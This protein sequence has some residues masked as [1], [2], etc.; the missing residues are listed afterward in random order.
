M[1]VVKRLVQG[2]LGRIGYEVRALEPLRSYAAEL[3]HSRIYTT[4]TYS[5]WLNDSAFQAVYEHIS[6]NTMVDLYRCYDLWQLVAEAAKLDHGDIIEVGSYRGGSGCLMSARS[7]QLGL[8]A[9][10]YLC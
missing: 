6:Q 3:P 2:T 8:N 9:T 10:V 5:P 4:A 7:A 1:T